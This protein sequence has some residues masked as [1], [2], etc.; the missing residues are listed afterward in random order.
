MIIVEGVIED[1]IFTNEANGYTVCEIVNSKRNVT[2]V[3]YM[4]FINEGETLKV[5]GTW[6]THPDYGQ[7]LKVESFEK[8]MPDTVEA[9]EKY[10]G[11][12]VIKG[13][14]KATAKKIV[15]KFGVESL[16]IIMEH[17]ERLSEIKGLSHARALEIGQAMAKQR[18]FTEIV[19]FL[20]KY[21]ISPIYAAR[22]YKAFGENTLEAIR[23]NPYKLTDEIPAINFKTV[24]AIAKSLGIEPES[25][26]RICSGVKYVLIKASTNGHIYLPYHE[27]I[28]H[29]ESLLNVRTESIKNALMSMEFDGMIHIERQYDFAEINNKINDD[30]TDNKKVKNGSKN[31]IKSGSNNGNK[32]QIYVEN[33]TNNND[34]NDTDNNEYTDNDETSEKLAPRVYLKDLYDAEISVTRRLVALSNSVIL[35]NVRSKVNRTIKKSLENIIASIEAEHNIILAETQKTAIC[36]TLDNGVLVITGGPGTGKTTIIKCIIKLF[37]KNNCKVALAA[38]TGRAAKRMTEATGY[39]ARTI[40]RLLEIGYTDDELEMSFMRTDVNPIDADVIIID[41]V[42]MVDVFLM[43][44]LLKAIKPGARL[45]LVGDVDQLPSVGPGNVLKDIIISNTIKTVRLTE[46]FRQAE[47]SLIVVNAH[48]INRG[49]RPIL[50]DKSKDFFFIERNNPDDIINLIIDLCSR[51]I[52]AQYGYDPFK[53]IQVL[54]PTRKGIV[55]VANLNMELQKKL[56]PKT[57]SKKEKAFPGYTYREGDKVMQIKNNYNIKW[58]KI[59]LN[60]GKNDD[61]NNDKNCIYSVDDNAGNNRNKGNNGDN[62][63]LDIFDVIDLH[64]YGEENQNEGEGIFNGDTGVIHH[65]DFD[66]EKIR[67][68]FD[69]NRIVDYSFDAFDEIEPAYAITIHKSQGSEFPVVIMPIYPGPPVLM[70]R[71]LLYTA[72]TRA[73][74]LVI[75]AGMEGT[76]YKMVD[77]ARETLRYSGLADK[78]IKSMQLSTFKL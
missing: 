65:I 19:S 44:S 69:D 9:I 18:N 26:L 2:L 16:N 29:A 22:I 45:I 74:D 8:I 67:I 12:G 43:D 57:R 72:I 38:P 32:D 64:E 40:H 52:P 20:H 11:S 66:E 54:T 4:P 33:D 58:K 37:E 60:E 42:S 78:L 23:N 51:R 15:R 21:N 7:Q 1:I 47:K 62:D 30:K 39:E 25:R 76:L 71:N 5:T 75:I 55:G 31:G 17:P 13:L 50:N 59:L 49:E 3:G 53:D 73:R 34:T 61:R 63:N 77:N 68:L 27:L 10:L 48:R 56:N 28:R 35:Q 36:E 46:V 6:V 14:G 24:D 70:T 41:E